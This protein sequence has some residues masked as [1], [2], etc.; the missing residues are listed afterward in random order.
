[1]SSH[2]A[3]LLVLL[4]RVCCFP[5]LNI[6]MGVGC[7]QSYFSKSAHQ[8][9]ELKSTKMPAML[10]V[11]ILQGLSASMGDGYHHS[12]ES[13]PSYKVS[14]Q[15]ILAIPTTETLVALYFPK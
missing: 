4:R 1:M 6:P 8:Y 10:M 2:V 7:V 14:T 9:F 12:P 11:D 5:V 13:V 3:L 15:T